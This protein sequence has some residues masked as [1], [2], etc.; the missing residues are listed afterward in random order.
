M[1]S[2][3]VFFGKEGAWVVAGS[4]GALALAAFGGGVLLAGGAGFWIDGLAST[5]LGEIIEE[6]VGGVDLSSGPALS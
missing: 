2:S 3:C 4:A 5:A 6:D 1:T